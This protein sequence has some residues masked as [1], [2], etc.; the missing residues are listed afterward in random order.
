[1]GPY[2]H[3]WRNWIATHEQHAVL[4]LLVPV[5]ALR[6]L[7]VLESPTPYGYVWDYYH[8]GVR[9]LFDEG[10]L[11]LAEDCWQC[12]HPPFF[13]L[14][15]LPFYAVGRGLSAAATLG[16]RL[17]AGLAMVAAA[18]VV[19]FGS[20]LLRLFGCQGASYLLGLALLTVAPI[21]FISSYGA[22]ADIVVTAI[23]GALFYYLTKYAS[24]PAAAGTRDVVVIGVLAG[25]AMATKYSGLTGL[26]TAG[27]VMGFQLLRGSGLRRTVGHGIAILGLCLA[28][29]GWKYV[30]NVGRYGQV[31]HANGSASEGLSL[32]ARDEGA[33][34]EFTTLR[35]AALARLFGRDA[36]PGDLTTFAVYRSVPT[37]LHAL[38]WSDM[39]FFSVRSRHGAPGDPYPYK[40]IPVWLTMAVIVLGLVPE[41]LA[42]VGL[43]VSFRRPS[44]VPLLAATFVTIA[45]YLWWVVPQESWALKTKYILAL[46]PIG[47]LYS[48]IGQAWLERHLPVAAR[49]TAGLLVALVAGALAYQA[50]FVGLL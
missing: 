29:G 13:Y 4:A 42:V 26:A 48:V 32:D 22:E 24:A 18:V 31:F 1:V 34:Y 40:S 6:T 27:L 11:P 8:D 37:A 38:V 25:L 50:A 36:P 16:L 30:D 5:V 28:V 35:L 47:V 15:G 2:S 20:R 10:R 44:L 9:V 39:S 3:R 14:V 49:V 33:D 46:L 7:L 23:L 19:Y 43:V 21:L 45:A 12:Y 41:A 17:T